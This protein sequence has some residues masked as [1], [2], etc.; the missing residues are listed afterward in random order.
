M[1]NLSICCKILLDTDYLSSKKQ[2][3][4]LKEAIAEDKFLDSLQDFF[5]EVN[6]FLVKCGC[7]RCVDRFGGNYPREEENHGVGEDGNTLY[8]KQRR[9]DESSR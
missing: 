8:W 3:I 5:N 6:D 7:A 2:L 4:L 1:Q 9:R